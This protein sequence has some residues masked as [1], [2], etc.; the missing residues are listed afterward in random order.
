MQD[1]INAIKNQFTTQISG[2]TESKISL[3]QSLKQTEGVVATLQKEL[4]RTRDRFQTFKGTTSNLY[5]LYESVKCQIFIDN[6]L[7]A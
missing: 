5:V 4:N 7:I 1:E 6:G 2:L 3:E